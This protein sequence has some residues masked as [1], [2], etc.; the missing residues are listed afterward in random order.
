[1][2]EE[3][4]VKWCDPNCPYA[5]FPDRENLDGA[6]HTFIALYCTKYSRL[7]QKSALCLD[8]MG[9]DKKE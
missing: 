8:F 4:E 2:D 6:C 3:A 9:K 5:E 1:M 7:V